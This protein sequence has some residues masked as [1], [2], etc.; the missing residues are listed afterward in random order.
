MEKT[1]NKSELEAQLSGKSASI[2]S[3]IEALQKEVG[4]L[5]FRRILQ[6]KPIVAVG[7]AIA[8]G[9]LLG[10]VFGGKGKS[11]RRGSANFHSSL[12]EGYIDS[13]ADDVRRLTGK[14]K[15]VSK[16]VRE[17]LRD[18]VPLIVYSPD[19]T[20]TTRGTIAE[21]ADLALKTAAGFA[22]KAAI[23]YATTR[24]DLEQLLGDMAE[25]TENAA[26]GPDVTGM[27]LSGSA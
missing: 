5:S 13:V 25:E 14:G 9:L 10:L 24:I 22:V 27:P 1:L 4:A 7:A 11:G 18:R 2:T 21:M 15:D 12:V 16:S 8:T 20:G 26:D 19:A 6:D 17:A 3:R 23:D